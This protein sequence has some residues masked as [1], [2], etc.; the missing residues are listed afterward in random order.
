[1]LCQK[2]GKNQANTHFKQVVNGKVTELH[3][4]ADC[5][6][7]LGL[8][9]LQVFDPFEEMPFN[10]HGAPFNINSLLGGMFTQTLPAAETPAKKCRFCGSTFE[11]FAQNA[12]AGCA[13]CYSEFSEELLPSIRKIHGKTRHV[14]KI[15]ESASQ[16]LKLSRELE[17][18]KNQLKQAV[19]EQEYEKAATLR[20]KIKEIEG[21]V[22][23]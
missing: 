5:A 12:L 23:G 20:D 21:K 11:D 8:Q 3:L 17:S 16:T 13:N 4:C 22:N 10:I 14:G 19:D 2:C 15:P 7:E 18:L 6:R 1:M 9:T